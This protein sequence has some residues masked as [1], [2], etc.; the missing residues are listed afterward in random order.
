MK[1][2][3]QKIPTLVVFLLSA[4]FSVAAAQQQKGEAPV[5]HASL[6]AVI[7]AQ[8]NL[9]YNIFGDIPGFTAARPAKD[10][11][12]N[13]EIFLLRNI[14]GGA[15]LLVLSLPQAGFAQ[16]KTGLANRIAG[17]QEGPFE[18]P[19]HPVEEDQ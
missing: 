18:S 17:G 15:Q 1:L 2:F 4:A 8:E 12:A 6:G 11:G 9:R 19:L 13:V 5:F 7:D 3:D 14:E 10:L 16:F